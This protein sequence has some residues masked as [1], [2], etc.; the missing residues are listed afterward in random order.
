[1]NELG[2]VPQA[3]DFA[4]VFALV[5]NGGAFSQIS[6]YPVDFDVQ[7][8]NNLVNKFFKKPVFSY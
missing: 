8:V 6:A 3:R 7:V 4:P 5:N 1:M 2:S